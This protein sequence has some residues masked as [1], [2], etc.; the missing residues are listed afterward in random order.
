MT[1]ALAH[2]DQAARAWAVGDVK[3][4]KANYGESRF[5]NCILT[6][7][8]AMGDIDARNAADTV[9]AID[10]ALGQ[11]GKTVSWWSMWVPCSAGMAC[12]LARLKARGVAIEKVRPSDA[13]QVSRASRPA[14]A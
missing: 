12:V 2:A 11:P 1:W 10:T 7:V 13:R 14:A 4:V 5:S 3:T 6:A 9:A 8:Q